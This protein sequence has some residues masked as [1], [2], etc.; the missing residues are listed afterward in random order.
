MMCARHAAHAYAVLWYRCMHHGALWSSVLC[1]ALFTPKGRPVQCVVLCTLCDYRL[2]CPVPRPVV[3]CCADRCGA[4]L[5]DGAVP[6]G[7]HAVIMIAHVYVLWRY[8]QL[9]CTLLVLWYN[10]H[11]GSAVLYSTLCSARYSCAVGQVVLTRTAFLCSRM[12]C[13][14]CACVVLNCCNLLR[15]VCARVMTRAKPQE[16]VYTWLHMHADDHAYGYPGV[17]MTVHVVFI[18]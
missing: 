17:L 6:C 3:R 9:W 11:H 4:V 10:V 12:L 7:T 18:I 15:C 8:V 14:C 13:G 1:R 2:L 5:C 16:R